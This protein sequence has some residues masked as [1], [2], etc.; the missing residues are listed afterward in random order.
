MLVRKLIN[1]YLNLGIKGKL[2]PSLVIRIHLLNVLNL[3][4][5]VVSIVYA[6]INSSVHEMATLINI[7][8]ILVNIGIYGLMLA[9]KYI[10]AFFSFLLLSTFIG[11][12]LAVLFGKYIASDLLFCTGIA[13]SIAMFENRYRMIFGVVLNLTCYILAMYFYENYQPIFHE[14]NAQIKMFYYPNAALFLI[15]LFVLVFLLKSENQR[16]EKVLQKKNNLLDSSN[17]KNEELI[18]HILPQKIADELKDRG[19]VEPKLYK[20]VTVM[21]TDFYH[22]TQI[23]EKMTAMQLVKEL[24]YYFKAFDEIIEK[25][26]IEKLKTIG[27]A[28]MC[29]SGIPVYRDDHAVVTV[30]AALEIRDK[31]QKIFNEKNKNGLEAWKI[32]IGIHTG[33]VVGGII[34]ETKFAFDIWGDTVNVASRMESSGEPGKINISKSTYEL[35][36]DK[37]ICQYRGKV[38]AKHKG[39]ID[40]YFVEEEK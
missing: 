36:K 7:I 23:A 33:S 34:G 20:N 5:L 11:A 24:D 37:F 3:S 4:C 25:Y 29:V 40:M 30:K 26:G 39:D 2:D 16:F 14:T 31:V 19:E 28:Y 27:D 1:Q 15:T 8:S 21:F 22:F 10:T 35:V 38:P 17:K 32:R 9:K 6:W 18:R 13:Y 12:I